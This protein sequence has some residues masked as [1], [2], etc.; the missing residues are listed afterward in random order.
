[1]RLGTCG[2]SVGECERSAALNLDAVVKDGAGSK[3]FFS[4]TGAGV[5]NFEELD[6]GAG[7]VLDRD[8]HVGGAAGGEDEGGDGEHEDQ[9]SP[10]RIHAPKTRR[11]DGARKCFA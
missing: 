2:G 9:E 11:M 5:V 6:G 10:F 7:L 4:E 3:G 8:L 1:M